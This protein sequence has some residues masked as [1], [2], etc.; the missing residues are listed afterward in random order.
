MFRFISRFALF[1]FLSGL[2]ISGL[3][4]PTPL[5]FGPV[6]LADAKREAGAIELTITN[7][8]GHFWSSPISE[9]A[10]WTP[11]YRLGFEYF[12]TTGLRS[13]GL[14]YRDGAGK[15]QF[16]TSEELPFAEGWRKMS[17][18]L[19]QIDLTTH[20]LGPESRFHFSM[21]GKMGD[22]IRF[23]NLVL[24]P[25]TEAERRSAQEKARVW[26]ERLS[27]SGRI[28]EYFRKEALHEL[29]VTTVADEVVIAGAIDREARLCELLPHQSSA[30]AP[31]EWRVVKQLEPGDFEVSLPRLVGGSGRDR[32][33]S[34][35]ALISDSGE[36]LSGAIWPSP[37]GLGRSD[38][39]HLTPQTRKGIGTAPPFFKDG[40]HEIFEL[41]IGHVT[42]NLVIT[43]ILRRGKQEGL[44][45]FPFEGEDFSIH[46]H[47]LEVYTEHVRCL[48]ENGIK[49]SGILLVPNAK[50]HG[51]AH[52]EAEGHGVY[53]MPD[54]I[55]PEGTRYYR[56]ALAVLAEHFSKPDCHIA[57]WIIH[58]EVDQA[59]T[60][61]EMGD[62]PLERFFETYHRS[63]RL[64][65]QAFRSRDAKARVFP[66]FTHHWMKQSGGR[67][68]YRVADLFELFA[69][70]SAVEGDF[71]WGV[72]YH[73]YPTNL[74]NPDTWYDTG[75][76]DSIESDYITPRNLQVLPRILAQPEYLFR[77]GKERT[78]LLSEQGF[79]TPTLS[80]TDQERQLAG[81]IYVF[82]KISALPT[83]EAF[84]LHRYQD[85][86]DRE[87][88][89]RL[90]LIDEEGN[91]KLGW[92]AYRALGTP[93][94]DAFE[95]LADEVMAR[96]PAE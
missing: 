13:L 52:L 22:Q 25:P 41:G 92:E 37:D 71:E 94:A 60:W 75:A 26:E 62:Q 6:G 23:R 34:R 93:Q 78:I 58:N 12:S 81:L 82:R 61:T 30:V 4:G 46:P 89:L 86:P 76:D 28:G 20:P 17:F 39:A 38:L 15:I 55:T 59:G 80:L 79:N 45:P 77:G 32:L 47:F 66:S 14:R 3:A 10:A 74:R 44:I 24:R 72:A 29:S 49:V 51:M 64:A 9:S 40:S 31:L 83:I 63:C 69:R 8:G 53:A 54:L 1:A 42:S 16:V 90:G 43:N 87:G 56:A 35:F 7:P 95:T 48:I 67:G 5:Q 11:D 96:P 85:M 36:I 68:T 88:G 70:A 57:N 2:T 21:Q 19:S 18:D 50:N 33:S 73:P 91:R 84:H 65:Y 27:E